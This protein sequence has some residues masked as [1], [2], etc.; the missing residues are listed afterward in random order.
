MA[1]PAELIEDHYRNYFPSLY[2][3]PEHYRHLFFQDPDNAPDHLAYL[4][5]VCT[6]NGFVSIKEIAIAFRGEFTKDHYPPEN[7]GGKKHL[8]VCETCNNRAGHQFESELV[9]QMSVRSYNKKVPG[10]T[11]PVKSTVTVIPGRYN[12]EIQIGSDGRFEISFK[13]KTNA[14]VPPLDDWLEQSKTD[15]NWTADITVTDP[16]ENKVSRALLK[17]AYLYCFELW[18]YEF[19]YSHTAEMMRKVLKEEL[20]YPL[21]NPSFWLTD[22]L[23]GAALSPG[24]YKIIQPADWKKFLVVME[25]TDLNTGYQDVIGVVV[26]GPK[27]TEWKDLA[28]IQ[29]ILDPEPE[30][31]LSFEPVVRSNNLNGKL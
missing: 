17:A 15:N 20:A 2:K 26:P 1:V 13:P 5:P 28:R 31:V 4:C 14:K 27:E 21:R 9:K 8:L 24:V 23:N 11:I 7:V 25:L 3:Y 18:A 6:E 30:L 29:S 16:D 12:S 19:V 10:A 22:I